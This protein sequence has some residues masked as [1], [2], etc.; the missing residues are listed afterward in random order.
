[1]PFTSDVNMRD[2]P[3][4]VQASPTWNY[5]DIFNKYIQTLKE[6]IFSFS[7]TDETSITQYFYGGVDWT[8]ISFQVLTSPPPPISPETEMHLHGHAHH[9]STN[10]QDTSST[11]TREKRMLYLTGKFLLEK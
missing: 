9:D 6:G 1:M 3:P 7:E 4:D 8:H 10:N 5:V 11:D 2:V